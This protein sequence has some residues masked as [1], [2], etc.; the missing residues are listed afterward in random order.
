MEV[1]GFP[2]QVGGHYVGFLILLWPCFFQR[3]AREF[4]FYVQMDACLLPFTA[5]VCGRIKI[6]VNCNGDEGPVAMKTDMLFDCHLTINQSYE[7][8]SDPSPS[9]SPVGKQSM[10]FRLKSG[11]VGDRKTIIKPMG[12]PM[13]KQNGTKV[14]PWGGSHIYD[15]RRPR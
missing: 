5:K 4:E 9:D 2:H 15:A 3:N 8:S 11:R 14:D 7:L 12:V 13:S 6:N 1:Y 10:T